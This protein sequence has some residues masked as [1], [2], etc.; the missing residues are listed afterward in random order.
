L[1]DFEGAAPALGVINFNAKSGIVDT[2]DFGLMTPNS[3]N[4][5]NSNELMVL[6]TNYN[7]VPTFGSVTL[8]NGT[9]LS[10]YK[11]V[12]IT[13]YALNAAAAYKPAYLYAS[14]TAFPNS[15]AWSTTLGS[16]GLIA[17]ITGGNP[18]AG[19]GAYAT[20]TFD[21]TNPAVASASAI[22]ALTGQTLYLGFG[23]S[24]GVSSGIT[25]LYF[26]DDVTLVP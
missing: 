11:G 9:V 17:Q 1:Q 16:G 18:I 24:G 12:K 8:P 14:S 21:L 7:S 23:Q 10:N 6:S 20:V 3:I 15:Q 5:N 25:P 2:T 19:A 22:A 13:Y 4:S 26:I